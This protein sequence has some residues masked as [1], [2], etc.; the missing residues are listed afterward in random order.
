MDAGEATEAL[1]AYESGS[2][3]YRRLADDNP[4]VIEFQAGLATSYNGAGAMLSQTGR[5]AEAMK[6]FES[7]LAIRQKLA[8]DHPDVSDFAS[9]VGATLNNVADID[10]DAKRFD[11]ARARLRQAVEWQ[12]KAL[13]SYPAEPLYRLF[14]GNHLKNLITASRGQGDPEGAAEAEHEL[15]ALLESDPG[16]EPVDAR[17]AAV[18]KA[19]QPPRDNAERLR[20]ARRIRQGPSC[21]GR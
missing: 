14:L 11:E 5:P 7:A 13:S 12:R 6:A 10:L 2:A 3:I 21:D 16:M 20:L 1:K 9:Q 18:I 17:L 4:A 19:D 8:R 15:A